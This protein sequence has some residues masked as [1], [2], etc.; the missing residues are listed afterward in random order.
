MAA[1]SRLGAAWRKT[2][3]DVVLRIQEYTLPVTAG[4][5]VVGS[6]YRIT[7]VGTTNFVAIGAASNTVGV[8]FVAGARGSLRHGGAA[9]GLFIMNAAR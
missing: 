3:G 5:F 2:R 6:T 4:A 1:S 9:L 8:L 7:S